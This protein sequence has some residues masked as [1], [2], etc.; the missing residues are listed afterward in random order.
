MERFPPDSTVAHRWISGSAPRFALRRGCTMVGK[1]LGAASALIALSGCLLTSP[2]WNQ[3]FDDH[4]APVPLQAWTG[5]KTKPVKFECAQAYHGGLYPLPSQVNW[6]Q[7]ADVN[8]Q[9]QPLLDSKGAKIFG[10]SKLTA[11][12]AA[13][14][15]LDGGN[16]LYYSAVRATQGTGSSKVAYKTFSKPGLECLGRE[17]GKAASWF[18]WTNKG[19]TKTYSDSSTEI[20]YV[21]FRATS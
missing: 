8:P 20:P 9:Q 15:R 12:P 19:C 5:D 3:A 13:C 11:L 14:W 16:G 17:N 6:V 1:T 21:I 10:A 7:V 18:G 4:T 2:Y